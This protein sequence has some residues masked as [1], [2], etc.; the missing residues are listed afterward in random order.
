MTLQRFLTGLADHRCTWPLGLVRFKPRPDARMSLGPILVQ[1]VLMEV[2]CAGAGLI[3]MGLFATTPMKGSW[4]P[5]QFALCLGLASGL[6]YQVLIRVAWNR[7][8]AGL[9]AAGLTSPPQPPPRRWWQTFLVA[10]FYTLV[11]MVLTPLALLL[12][13]D[14]AIGTAQ[15]RR[16]RAELEA[17]GEWE[18]ALAADP[19]NAA[20]YNNLA[21]IYGHRGPITNAFVYYEKAIEL[22]PKE[23]VYH[24]NLATTVALFRKDVMEHYGFK[25]EQKVFDLA[26]GHY[27]KAL[28][29]DPESFL[30]ATDLA[31]TFYL[32]KPPRY[33]EALTAWAK[34]LALAS[35]DLEREGIR[36]HLARLQVQAGKLAEART[37]LSLVTNENYAVLKERIQKNLDKRERSGAAGGPEKLEGLDLQPFD[38][39]RPGPLGGDK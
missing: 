12:A 20:I 15:W 33:E 18:K 10:P 38:R 22:E 39:T 27:R 35:D 8:A 31:Q 2:F 36:V 19:K 29:L 28:E 7:R 25:D 6:F 17:R 21:G 30:I 11:F 24:Q 1:L 26:L 4:W 37:N 34:A 5:M 16:A 32:I 23:A 14:N 13:V 9:R 3:L